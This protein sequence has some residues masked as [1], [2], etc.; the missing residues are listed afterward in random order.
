MTEGTISDV[1]HKGPA[2]IRPRCITRSR[3]N[4]SNNLP[5]VQTRFKQDRQCTYNVNL[6]RV[7]ATIVVMEKQCVLH[8]LSISVALDIQHAMRMRH[9][10]ICGLPR[11]TIFFPI[12]S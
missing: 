3:I 8:N 1:E 6:R 7:P 5:R 4:Q 11:S 9:I 2:Y 12:S 10:I